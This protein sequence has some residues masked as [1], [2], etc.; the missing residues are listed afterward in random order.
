MII[1]YWVNEESEK[2][3]MTIKHYLPM[4]VMEHTLNL[5]EQMDEGETDIAYRSRII[6]LLYRLVT[7]NDVHFCCSSSE[8]YDIAHEFCLYLDGWLFEVEANEDPEKG[9]FNVKSI[10]K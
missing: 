5:I 2:E 1:R 10:K 8:T 7:E 3:L 9:F 4:N 6:H